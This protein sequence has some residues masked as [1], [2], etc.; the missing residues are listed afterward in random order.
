MVNSF[1]LRKSF[2]RQNAARTDVKLLI[3]RKEEPAEVHPYRCACSL[4]KTGEV[5]QCP[6]HALAEIL[7]QGRH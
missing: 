7:A 5:S 1:K 6:V 2:Q 3:L 4:V